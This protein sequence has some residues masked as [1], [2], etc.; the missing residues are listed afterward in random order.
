MEEGC[1]VKFDKF[2]NFV[3]NHLK[4]VSV[5]SFKE[6]ENTCLYLNMTK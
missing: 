1:V 4:N 3:Y 5:F 2:L 6:P